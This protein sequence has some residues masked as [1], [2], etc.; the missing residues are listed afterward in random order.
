M[1]AMTAMATAMVMATAT[2]Q[3]ARTM[4]TTGKDNNDGKDNNS[5]D[6]GNDSVSAGGGQGNVRLV[7]GKDNDSKDHG[8]DSVSAVSGEGN[9]RLVAV[10]CH[11]LV[12]WRLHTLLIIQI[13]FGINLF[14]SKFYSACPDMPNRIYSIRIY[15]RFIGW[16][17]KLV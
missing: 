15:S 10:L 6:V 11:A 7:A 12:V 17:S 14:W 1:A 3:Q 4:R 16:L 9:V 13:C 2:R 5:M 8:D